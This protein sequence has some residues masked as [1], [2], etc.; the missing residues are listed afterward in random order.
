MPRQRGTGKG[1]SARITLRF[2]PEELAYYGKRAK[3]AGVS[4][5][6]FIRQRLLEGVVAESLANIEVRLEALMQ[7]IQTVSGGRGGATSDDLLLSVFTSEALLAT[8][9]QS[10]DP[11][12]LY[13]AQEAAKAKLKRLKAAA[14]AAA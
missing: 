8:V 9:V 2:E 5:S 12:T 14:V 7:Q 4:T 6:A 11:Q 1:E 10:Q 13:S 3:V